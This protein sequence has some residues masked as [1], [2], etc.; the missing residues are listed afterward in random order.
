MF[1]RGAQVLAEREDLDMVGAKVAHHLFHFVQV[2]AEAEHQAGL[3]GDEGARAMREGQ[4]VERTLVARAEPDLAI[5][6]RDGL[7]VVVED[8]GVRV[9]DNFHGVARALEVGD[10]DFDLAAWDA[11][12]NGLDGEGEEFGAAVLTVV[13][14]HAGDDGVAE[15]EGGAG[16]GDAAGFVEID[17][18]RCAF[19]DRAE[20]A[21]AGADVAENHEGGG[22]A[23]P[24]FADVGAG[25]AFADGVEV[26]IG[27]EAFQFVVVFA[28]GGR[29]A[30]PVGARGFG[31]YGDEHQLYFSGWR[32]FPQG[33]TQTGVLRGVASK[34]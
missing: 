31:F 11:L 25:G 2:F 22:A 7:D 19:L 15:A 26:E 33:M 17:R 27:D 23:V 12:A 16:F 28:G 3:G 20:P 4:H 30:E 34:F 13:T 21:A 18:E 8:V 14:I 1:L 32:R 24:A 10:E 9:H 29:G 5:E 6:A